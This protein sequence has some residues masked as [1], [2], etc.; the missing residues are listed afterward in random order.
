M[1]NIFHRGE[2]QRYKIQSLNEAMK[3]VAEIYHGE[4]AKKI[5]VFISHKHDD[6]NDLKDI[7]GFLEKNYNV[8]AYIDSRDTTMP[9][10]TSGETAER[11]KDRIKQC[12]RFIL[13]ATNGAIESKWCNWELGYGDAQK[14]DLHNIA[15][16]P[17]K[18]TNT[19][20][21]EYKGNEYM[22]IYP[23]IVYRDGSTKYKNGEKVLPGYYLRYK[24]NNEWYLKPLEEWLS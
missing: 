9:I 8:K 4:Q 22:E 17:M 16:F 19:K 20:D 18:E 12:E 2:F 14:F 13:L 15:L 6:L 3:D 10:T 24:R 1:E 7:I 21:N 11:I 5:T 23:Y